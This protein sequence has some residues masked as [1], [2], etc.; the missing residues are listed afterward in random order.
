MGGRNPWPDAGRRAVAFVAGGGGPALIDWEE[1]RIGDVR[2]DLGFCTRCGGLRGPCR[3]GNGGMLAG[4][5][6]AWPDDGT[7]A[8]ADRDLRRGV[9]SFPTGGGR[10][11]KGCPKVGY[12][13]PEHLALSLECAGQ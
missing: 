7:A 2:L 6:G 9:L 13:G 5:T 11:G 3:G 12:I 10:R 8:A 4:R 1:A